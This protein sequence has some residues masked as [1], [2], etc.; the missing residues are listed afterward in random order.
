MQQLI[1]LT[2]YQKSTPHKGGVRGVLGKI[3]YINFTI[4]ESLQTN[5]K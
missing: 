4:N 5:K 1:K 3:D 2:N